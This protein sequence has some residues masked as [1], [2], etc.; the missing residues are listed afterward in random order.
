[1]NLS[2]MRNCLKVHFHCPLKVAPHSAAQKWTVQNRVEWRKNALV[3]TKKR[4][5]LVDAQASF[6][7][8]AWTLKKKAQSSSKTSSLGNAIIQ[9]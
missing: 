5:M 1:M 6:T 3:S 7:F 4:L 2:E 8:W 9:K